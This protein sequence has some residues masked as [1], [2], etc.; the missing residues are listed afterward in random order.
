ML[1]ID[2]GHGGE[3]G[4]A[5]SADGLVE[6]EVNLDI[7]LRVR[8]LARFLG[9]PVVLT[10]DSQE[11]DYPLDAK[12]TAARKK[13]DTRRRV[14][15]INAIPGAVLVSIHQNCY[16]ATGPWGAQVLY[17][18][19]ESSRVLGER[20]HSELWPSWPRKTGGSGAGG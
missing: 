5:I 13:W 15:Q 20:L 11:L 8:D 1:V 3:D 7:A 4:G 18:P 19:L 2:A 12:T 16:P 6:S 10:R 9:I 14:E 17:G